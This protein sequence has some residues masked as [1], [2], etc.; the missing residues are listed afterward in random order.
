MYAPNKQI[1]N[2]HAVADVRK[3]SP[4]S[5][6]HIYESKAL[7]FTLP[8]KVIRFVIYIYIER[9]IDIDIDI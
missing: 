7:I 6:L 3:E 5:A 2:K 1:N 8:F 4:V 9:D